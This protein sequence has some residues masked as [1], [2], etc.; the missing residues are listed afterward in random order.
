MKANSVSLEQEL[1][2]MGKRELELELALQ[3]LRKRSRQ[4]GLA[5]QHDVA[6]KAWALF[7]EFR[8]E[9]AEL[10]VKIRMIEAKV[11]SSRRPTKK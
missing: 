2:A 5:G 1:Q 7:E 8:S 6:D 9:L 3:E 10:Q 11:Y 4:A